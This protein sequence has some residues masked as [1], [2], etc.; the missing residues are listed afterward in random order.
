MK[1]QEMCIYLLHISRNKFFSSA[2]GRGVLVSRATVS[3]N[4]DCLQLYFVAEVCFEPPDSLSSTSQVLQL[5]VCPIISRV[6]YLPKS[7]FRF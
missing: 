5:H 1:N 4:P 7:L 3:C 6:S 2:R